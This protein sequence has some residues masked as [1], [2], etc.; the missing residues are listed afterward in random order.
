MPFS[1]LSFMFLAFAW[2]AVVVLAG[3]GGRARELVFLSLNLLFL[4]VFLL[5]PTGVASTLAFCLLGYGLTHLVQQWPGRGMVLAL[6]AYTALFV[7]MRQYGFLTWLLAD[8]FLTQVLS[9]IGLSFLFF[10]VVHV[11]VDAH[12]GTIGRLR[13]VMFLNYCLNFSTFVM[14]PIQRY[15]DFDTQWSAAPAVEQMTVESQLDAVLRVLVGLV[16]AYIL[17]EWCRAY[18]LQPD[19]D[20]LSLSLLE[21][22]IL[23]YAFYFYLYF[24]FSGYCD[25]AIGLGRL[26]GI[27]PPENFNWPFLA[28]NVADFWQRQHRSLTLWLTDYVF[29]PLYRWTLGRP[30][31][32]PNRLLGASAALMITMLVSG[33]WHGTTAGFAL[34]GLVHGLYLVV[35]YLWDAMLTRRFGRRRIARWRA[36]WPV[37]AAGV[38]LTFNATAFA[39]VFFQ[40]DAQRLAEVLSCLS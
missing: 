3:L 40:L 9:T 34:F 7:Y 33:V 15:Q 4:S 8:R 39:F 10:K 24:N 22:A 26:L 28:R 31:L 13:P 14:G 19:T 18:A 21:S 23:V 16:K 1:P 20:L 12:A 32:G 2:S 25:F 11:M 6:V 29:S 35:Y 37:H 27:T 17:A 30:R 38:A 5:E 36:W